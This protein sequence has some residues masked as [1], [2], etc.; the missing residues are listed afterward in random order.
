MK[1]KYS[2]TIMKDLHYNSGLSTAF[3][4]FI[5]AATAVCI[6]C[7]KDAIEAYK[8]KAVSQDWKEVALNSIK[9]GQPAPPHPIQYEMHT[10]SST[11]NNTI[12]NPTEF[13]FFPDKK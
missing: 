3:R 2:E 12:I 9:A 11:V 8:V 1:N 6:F 13:D 7:G 5:P 10:T 4:S